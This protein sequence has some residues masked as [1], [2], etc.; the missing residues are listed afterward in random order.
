MGPGTNKPSKDFF[1]HNHW[2][3]YLD[4]DNFTAKKINSKKLKVTAKSFLS[5]QDSW[6][7]VSDL[8]L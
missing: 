8:L 5:E 2:G 1:T 6:R 7:A 4:K 3:K